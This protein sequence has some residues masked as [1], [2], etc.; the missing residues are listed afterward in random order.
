MLELVKIDK[1]DKKILEYAENIIKQSF[2]E[3]EY[4]DFADFYNYSLN[5]E[6]FIVYVIKNNDVNIGI[7]NIW[8]LKKCLFIEHFAI[9][10]KYRSKSYGSQAINIINNN[11][12]KDIFLEVNLPSNDENKKRI[13]FYEK[14]NYKIINIKYYQE[15][16]NKNKKRIEM[17]LMLREVN[18]K[19]KETS[20]KYYNDIVKDIKKIIYRI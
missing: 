13:K 5:R 19:N 9:E 15:A 3:D 20:D 8:D 14:N 2:E 12:K 6:E 1:K 4:R 10:K 17:N 7:L 16:Y 11:F 18:S